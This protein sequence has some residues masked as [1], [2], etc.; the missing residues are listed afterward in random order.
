MPPR[1]QRDFGS[2]EEWLRRARSNLAIARGP[3]S[4][5]I[6]WEDLCFEAQ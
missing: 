3:A 1:E 6:Y 4:D 5:D 2:P